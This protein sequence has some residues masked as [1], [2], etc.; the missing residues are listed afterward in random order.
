MTVLCHGDCHVFLGSSSL[1]TCEVYRVAMYG[2]PYN[3]NPFSP[4]APQQP[5]PAPDV[6]LARIEA[7]E[8]CG[9]THLSGDGLAAFTV[10]YGR[11]LQADWDGVMFGAWLDV[12]EVMPVGAAVLR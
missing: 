9:A 6:P 7:A 3:Y 8:R 10:R 5:A 1:C 2:T 4:H 12:G 11:V